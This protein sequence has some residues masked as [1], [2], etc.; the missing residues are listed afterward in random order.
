LRSQKGKRDKNSSL[1]LELE[2]GS[3]RDRN[4]GKG[5]ITQRGGSLIL[6]RKFSKGACI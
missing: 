3:R 2:K 1:L 6:E 4:L 5:A